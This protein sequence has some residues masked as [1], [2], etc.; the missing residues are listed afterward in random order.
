MK[1]ASCI[2]KSFER[3]RK[4]ETEG[5]NSVISSQVVQILCIFWNTWRELTS[6]VSTTALNRRKL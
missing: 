1:C 6:S 5:H 2:V 4:C 3:A